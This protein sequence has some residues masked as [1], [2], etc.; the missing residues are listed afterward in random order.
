VKSP[1]ATKDTK[2]EHACGAFVALITAETAFFQSKKMGSDIVDTAA[3]R[4]Y[5]L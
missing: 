1:E 3:H 5:L 2:S 4:D